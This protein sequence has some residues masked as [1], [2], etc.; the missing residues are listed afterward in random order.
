MRPTPRAMGRGDLA[1][2]ARVAIP[3]VL[4]SSGH[5]FRLLA[6]RIMLAQYS[7]DAIAA[8]FPAG[9]LCFALMAFFIGTAGFVNTFVA[10]FS[11][12]GQE[13]EAG[14]AVWQGI[15]LSVI[16]GCVVA[17]F[18]IPAETIFH[19]IG[20]SPSVQAEEVRYFRI[21][22]LGSFPGIVFAAI[23]AFWS[24]RGFT[25][26]VMCIDLTCAAINV[27]LNTLLIFGR[28]GFPELGIVGAAYATIVANVV[29]VSIAML[30]FLSP[31]NRRRFGTWS[32]RGFDWILFKRL[33][34]FGSPNG[35]QF[36]LDLLAFN[37]F[38]S[39][40]GRYGPLEQEAISIVFGING[41]AFIPVVGLGIAVSVLVG[42]GI[43]A[44]DLAFSKRAVSSGV[45]LGLIYSS[46]VAAVLLIAPDAVL[47]LFARE[48]DASQVEVFVVARH[49]LYYV[50][51]YLF[52]DTVYLV[53]SHAVKGAGDTY[54]CLRVA[55]F[56]WWVTMVL[57]AYIGIH[58]GFSMW[59][60]W[61]LLLANVILAAAIFYGRY[62]SG[63]WESMS[64]IDAEASSQSTLAECEVP[65]EHPH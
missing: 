1:H 41:T 7:A 47:G 63:R 58:A 19:W 38:I 6:D 16:G 64:V 57:P 62:R 17:L 26:V 15:Y 51:G 52:F 55:I 56:V 43:G 46:L 33:A 50:L 23:V 18:A 36:G 11:G 59:S 9:L 2:V 45:K 12:S 3:L 60:L 8:S 24:G 25:R 21:L 32:R 42:Q 61:K 34:Y 35:L 10:Q 49:C 39:L 22:A 48:G 44:G 29:G 20:H 53:F 27:G 14:S 40:L 13:D 31:A 54:F 37:V 28:G 5:A 4:A 30:L 65:G